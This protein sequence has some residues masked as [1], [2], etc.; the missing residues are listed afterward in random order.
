M[1]TADS[2]TLDWQPPKEDG[3]S[4]VSSYKIMLSKDGSDWSE[5]ATPAKLDKK[6]TAKNLEEGTKY[7]F[8]VIAVNDIGESK[9]LESECFTP[10]TQAG[11]MDEQLITIFDLLYFFNRSTPFIVEVPSAPV[12]PVHFTMATADSVT[13]DWQ[14]PKEDGGS[15]VSYQLVSVE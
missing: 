4:P 2:V 7:M 11:K 8:R 12:G 13:L 9:P 14:P 1:A 5:V 15:P 3:G 10:Q 6:Y